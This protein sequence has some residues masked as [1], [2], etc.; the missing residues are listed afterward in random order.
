ME[1]RISKLGWRYAIFIG[2]GM[3]M[4]F[5]L[6]ALFKY[7]HPAFMDSNQALW[8]WLI[9][10]VSVDIIAFPVLLWTL[11]KLPADTDVTY[12]KKSLKASEFVMYI[13]I[14]AGIILA[15]I[16]TGS[17]TH[18]I[19]L[20]LFVKQVNPISGLA[21][22]MVNSDP[23]SRFIIVGILQPVFEELVFRKLLIDRTIKYGE[24]L[25]VILSGMLFALNHANFQQYFFAFGMGALW[26]FIYARTRK[27][28]YTIALHI[29]VNSVTSVITA[30]LAV[31][32]LDALDH[33]NLDEI[34][35]GVIAPEA[36]PYLTT[37]L[38]YLIWLAFLFI[39]CIIGIIIWI[40]NR[41]K[42]ALVKGRLEPN[43][44]QIMRNIFKNKMMWIFFAVSIVLLI[45]NY[46]DMIAAS[47]I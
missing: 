18:N 20:S 5:V 37:M 32:Y 34:T 27:I 2:L 24:F 46:A 21:Q 14:T 23:W 44:K 47:A 9:V 28:G 38:I 26:A 25:S 36:M 11:R 4:Q 33:L 42:L 29:G 22:M 40:V 45:L 15:G 13:F 12:E 7:A 35:A 3:G 17:I 43:R 39:V 8:S 6:A 30:N 10:V 41:K 19:V 1:E 31:N 16:I